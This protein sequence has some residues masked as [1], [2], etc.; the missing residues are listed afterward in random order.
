MAIAPKR[1]QIIRAADYRPTPMQELVKV[2]QAVD[3][4]MFDG[5]AAMHTDSGFYVPI[6]LTQRALLQFKLQGFEIVDGKDYQQENGVTMVLHGTDKNCGLNIWNNPQVKNALCFTFIRPKTKVDPK[7]EVDPYPDPRV[8]HSTQPRKLQSSS[9]TVVYIL[10]KELRVF[11]QAL[12]DNGMYYDGNEYDFNKEQNISHFFYPKDDDAVD[13]RKITAIAKAIKAKGYDVVNENDSV[14]V[15]LKFSNQVQAMQSLSSK[16]KA[17]SSAPTKTAIG[18]FYNFYKSPLNY[19]FALLKKPRKTQEVKQT[20]KEILIKLRKAEKKFMKE[21]Q[22]SDSVVDFLINQR[23]LRLGKLEAGFS[24]SLA[25][26]VA[27][28]DAPIGLFFNLHRK[29]LNYL[30]A[31]LRLPRKS[32]EKKEI[33]ESLVSGLTKSEKKFMKTHNLDK[34]ILNVLL[35]QRKLTLPKP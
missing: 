11:E 13:S 25:A 29:P 21:H 2:F 3:K 16:A 33:I 17:Q 26:A 34:P 4:T 27:A 14:V 8:K 35:K 5:V 6:K 19:L 24:P 23:S 30:F 20:I 32:K 15:M 12:Y 31:L 1:V 28:T 18:I 10:P 7:Q 22:F 9:K